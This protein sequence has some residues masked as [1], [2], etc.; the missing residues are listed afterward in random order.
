ME[1]H[2]CKS[3]TKPWAISVH[4][5]QMWKLSLGEGQGQRPAEAEQGLGL[6][7]QPVP[8]RA[9]ASP[10]HILEC[11]FPLRLVFSVL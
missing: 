2:A 3:V 10:G 6:L 4:L 5:L 7:L 8:G 11:F 1:R 9:P